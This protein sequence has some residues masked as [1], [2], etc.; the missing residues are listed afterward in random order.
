MRNEAIRMVE[1]QTQEDDHGDHPR[2]QDE[3]HYF[4]SSHREASDQHPGERIDHRMAES[5]LKQVDKW[6]WEAAVQVRCCFVS[7]RAGRRVYV[8]GD[9]YAKRLAEA[10]AGVNSEARIR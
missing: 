6:R 8:H 3:V 5:D 7:V 10:S 9:M 1:G 4:E 2:M